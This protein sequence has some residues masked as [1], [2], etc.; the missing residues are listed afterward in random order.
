[1]TITRADA[2]DCDR[3]HETHTPAGR[4]AEWRRNGATKTW[5]TRPADFRVPVKYGMH[6]YGYITPDNAH[7]YHRADACPTRHVRVNGPD[8]E[9][10]GVVIAELVPPGRSGH[11]LT[12]VQ[13]TK[14]GKS[15]HRPGAMVD[16]GTKTLTYL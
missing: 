3:F 14:R 10:F 15:R 12:R 2:M 1:M 5:A 11:G 6:A 7:A 16:A 4:I 9:W 8:G 13:V